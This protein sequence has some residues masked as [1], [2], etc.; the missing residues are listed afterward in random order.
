MIQPKDLGVKIGSKEEIEWTGV[1]KNT[2]EML[3]THLI[4]IE[5]QK[6]IIKLCDKK[7]AKEKEN[8]K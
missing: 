8:F 2:E 7:I 3:R 1:K 5:C 4:E 6:E